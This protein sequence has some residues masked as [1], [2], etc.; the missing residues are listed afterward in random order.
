MVL[1]KKFSAARAVGWEQKKR[2]H[3]DYNRPDPPTFYRI[4]WNVND[5]GLQADIARQELFIFCVLFYQQSTT[6]K[7]RDI[8][9]HC[10]F[11]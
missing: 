4:P 6:G 11:S 7:Y 5:A 8:L 3:S 10:T 2:P 9:S 1:L